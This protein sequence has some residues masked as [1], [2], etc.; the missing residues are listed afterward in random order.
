VSPLL[1]ATG[2][3]LA[4][5]SPWLAIAVYVGVALMWM[6]PDRRLERTIAARSCGPG[7]AHEPDGP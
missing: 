6:V 4:F 1:Y 7:G 3:A 2:I 5:V